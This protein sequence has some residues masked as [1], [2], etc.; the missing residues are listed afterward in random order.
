MPEYVHM[1]HQS[2]VSSTLWM[3][4]GALV[5]FF[6]PGLNGVLAGAA[7]GWRA[8]SYA[9]ASR[10]A[11]GA[12]FF[13]G[14]AF[15]AGYHFFQLS[16]SFIYSGLG[17]LG[18]VVLTAVGLML[19]ALAA[20]YGRSETFV[21]TKMRPRFARASHARSHEGPPITGAPTRRLDEPL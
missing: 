11:L 20:V 13:S 1:K 17:L 8:G 15:F 2:A 12:T 9:R 4:I 7:G 3:T 21:T 10:A 19:G 18:W 14:M 16:P 5:F 6:A